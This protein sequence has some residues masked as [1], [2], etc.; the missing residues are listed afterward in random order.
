MVGDQGPFFRR[1]CRGDCFQTSIKLQGVRIDN[2]PMVL[3]RDGESG[4]GFTGCGGTAEEESV[5]GSEIGVETEEPPT[6][7]ERRSS[8]TEY[9]NS[10][11]AYASG[12]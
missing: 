6:Q 5:Q 12:E 2:L 7:S 9:K 11:P 3:L 10:P 8:I 4:R 1:G